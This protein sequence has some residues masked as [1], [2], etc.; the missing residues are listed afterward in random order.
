MKFSIDIYRTYLPSR[1]ILLGLKKR[2]SI[3]MASLYRGS[4][5]KDL[6]L[7]FHRIKKS[8]A[9]LFVLLLL[10]AC[11][12]KDDNQTD[13]SLLSDTTPP[14]ISLNGESFVQLEAGDEYNEAGAT[15]EDDIDGKVAVTIQGK[16]DTTKPGDYTLTYVARDRSDNY[17]AI[18]RTIS[19]IDST[20]PTLNLNG[21]TEI[22]LATGSEYIEQGATAVDSID[23]DVEV[24]IS[25]SVNTNIP[26]NYTITYTA[27]DQSGNDQILRRIV[28]VIDNQSPTLTLN[29]STNL[30]M[31]VGS[32]YLELGATAKDNVDDQIS[33]TISGKLNKDKPGTYIITY[34]ATDRSN[35]SQ[36][37]SRTITVIDSV[38][39]KLTLLGDAAMI[40]EAGT[41]FFEAGAKAIDNVDGPISV[42]TKGSVNT[43]IVG[44]YTL[45]YTATDSSGNQ[46]LEVRTI[47]V[48]DT[49]A[50]TLTLRGR[51]TV[52]FDQY[53]RYIEPGF[54]VTDN[55]DV[56]VNVSIIG[57]VDTTKI[58]DYLL[59]YTATDAAGNSTSVTR[60]VLIL[61]PKPFITIWKT[62]NE[63]L[64]FDNQIRII[65]SKDSN[66]TVDWGD[67]TIQSGISGG[68]VTHTYDNPGIY[69]VKMSGD[70]KHFYFFPYSDNRKLLSVEQWGSIRWSSMA[71]TFLNAK[72]MVMNATDAPDLS[73]VTN[74]SWMFSGAKSFNSDLSHWDVSNAKYM[75]AM[76][77]HALSFN[78]NISNWN[79]SNVTTMKVMFGHADAFEGDLS[80]WVVSNVTD[81]SAMFWNAASFNNDL[82]NWDV[83]NVSD[84]SAMFREAKSF[85]TDITGWNVS[86]VEDMS[87]M[88]CLAENFNQDISKW[89][90]QKVSAMG[91]MLDNSA[92][93]TK[94]YD[95]L[96]NSWSALP[97]LQQE[98]PLGANGITY[99]SASESARSVLVN[100]HGWTITDSG[101]SN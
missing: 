55:H 87:C 52:G 96:L 22:V 37:I 17:E 82:S 3:S 10:T 45:S 4:T 90:I 98:V 71:E 38:V 75:F 66:F 60:S 33:I 86:N 100:T 40:V 42:I 68:S 19:V 53:E 35:N 27:T 84:M 59:T 41:P 14:V 94:N 30:Q 11:G 76:F 36:S 28:S 89:D 20:P 63:G 51:S 1:E 95:L 5:N 56:T 81:M 18:S 12:G 85:N 101:L 15:A 21:D 62:D 34:T 93:T 2:L 57:E 25:G 80:K 79:V 64:S 31:E 29:G 46:A 44:N 26:N 49:T 32:E 69:T 39:P 77:N 47:E 97:D 72:N 61:D 58:G 8:L 48:V 9:Y 78:G 70:L 65:T 13:N 23:D 50:P 88:F 6:T 43:S 24:T 73:N 99:S 67:G 92:L 7:E 16:V 91:Q 83:S 54:D 74:F